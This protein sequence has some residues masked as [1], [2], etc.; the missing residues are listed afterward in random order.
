M[1]SKTFNELGLAS[2]HGAVKTP[3]FLLELSH[4][5][6]AMRTPLL[7]GRLLGIR[8]GRLLGRL[9]GMLLGRLLGL[10][11][12]LQALD[13]RWISWQGCWQGRWR[14]CQQ[15]TSG[16][17][18]V[19][20][21][22]T[23]RAPNAGLGNSQSELIRHESCGLLCGAVGSAVGSSVGCGLLCGL[24]ALLWA[25]LWAVGSSVYVT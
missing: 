6:L 18:R 4:R 25:P 7:C 1:R 8:L 14:R 19:Q 5:L 3:Q 16:V 10:P 13:K 17:V 12:V 2:R 24:W 20:V 15:T 23:G 21:E 22:S 11:M 9:F